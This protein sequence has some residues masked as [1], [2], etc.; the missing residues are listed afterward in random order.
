MYTYA[1]ACV[2]IST[3]FF[4]V[5]TQ[6]LKQYST[7]PTPYLILISLHMKLVCSVLHLS[8]PDAVIYPML[9]E[10]KYRCS[11]ELKGEAG[12]SLAH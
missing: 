4:T 9:S 7:C 3:L 2:D 12:V 6:V 10:T 5:K 8:I 11:V 1:Y